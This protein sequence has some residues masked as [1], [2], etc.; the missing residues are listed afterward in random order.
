MSQRDEFDVHLAGCVEC[1]AYVKTYNETVELGR[2]AFLDLDAAVS[3]DVPDDL[4][5]A[6]VAA[7]RA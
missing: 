6:I 3:A 4:V 5:K 7:R 1:V 2:A